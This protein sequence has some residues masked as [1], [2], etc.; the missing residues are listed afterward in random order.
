MACYVSCLVATVFIISA[1][2]FTF[3]I[4]KTVPKEYADRLPPRTKAIYKKVVAERRQL[5]NQGLLM[6]LIVGLVLAAAFAKGRLLSVC[7]VAASAFGIQYLYYMLAPKSEW[8]IRYMHLP[9]ERAAWLR[10]YRH[11]QRMYHISVLL[12]VIGAAI[13][14]F[15]MC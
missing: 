9:H 2:A 12:G 7:I 15:G 11:Y 8:M 4:D 10:V 3:L 14:G 1:I 6:G 5:A 13:M